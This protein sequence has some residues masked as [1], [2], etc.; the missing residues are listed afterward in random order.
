MASAAQ[1]KSP[2]RELQRSDEDARGRGA[3][4]GVV[5]V[6]GVATQAHI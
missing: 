2:S 1:P 5:G 3:I 4:A 6:L